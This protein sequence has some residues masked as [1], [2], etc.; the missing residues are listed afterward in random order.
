M[1]VAAL[2][3]R[4][5]RSDCARFTAP[6]A[7]AV[8]GSRTDTAERMLTSAIMAVAVSCLKTVLSTNAVPTAVATAATYRRSERR[9]RCTSPRAVAIAVVMAGPAK[10]V[11]SIAATSRKTLSVKSA[12]QTTMPP[13][14]E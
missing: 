2:L 14:A 6:A 12:I 5:L 4:L 3:T 1:P 13:S 9:K 10:G 11:I 7:P 8:S